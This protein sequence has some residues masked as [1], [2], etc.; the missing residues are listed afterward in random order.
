MK[1]LTRTIIGLLIVAVGASFLLTNLNILPFDVGIAQWWPL[2]IVAGGV[3]MLL[4][5]VRNYLWA[6]L[7]I[8]L[9]VLFQLKQ[10]GIVDV[11]PWQLFWPAIIIVLGVS[12]M[13]S[14]GS[15]RGKIAASDR[16]D[17]MAILSGSEVRV[18]S[19]DFKGSRVTSICGGAMID[20]RKAVIKK[21]ATIDVF[22]F[23]GGI[24]IIVP[25]HVMVKNNTSVI[26]GGVEQQ[27][28]GDAV[29]EG[30]P[31]LYVTGDVVMS[32]VEIKR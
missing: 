29:K 7:V 14:R 32:G 22:A 24:E 21:E 25:E 6:L 9:G 8:G 17:V 5:D 13:T 15:S 12:V 23:W 31:I 11:N 19:K 3:V 1:S 18:E 28:G 4:S 2:F 10:F 26:M 16:E 20:L 27:A 30:G